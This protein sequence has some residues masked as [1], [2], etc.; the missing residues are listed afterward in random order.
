VS[1]AVVKGAFSITGNI[2]CPATDVMAQGQLKDGD[3]YAVNTQD[4]TA[5]SPV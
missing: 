4:F 3:S 2:D 5:V 1:E